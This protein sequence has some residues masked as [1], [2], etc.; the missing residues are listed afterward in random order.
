MGPLV[1][2]DHKARVA[3]YIEKGVAEGA[4]PLLDGR[5]RRMRWRRLFPRA[6]PFSTTCSPEMTIAREEIFGPVLSVIRVKTLD[7]AIALVNSSP[8]RQRDFHLHRQRKS[9]ARIF[10]ARG[11]RHGRGQ[12]RRG[13]AHG[14]FPFAGWKNSFFGDLHAHGKDA[15]M[16][17]TEQKVLMTAGFDK[18]F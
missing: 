9:G 17:Y 18:W 2:K 15:V 13:R 5:D 10:G 3:G 1:T 8:L 14:F 4:K 6:R 11:S 12:R 16:F 7:E